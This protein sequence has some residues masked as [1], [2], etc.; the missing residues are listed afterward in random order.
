MSGILQ[1]KLNTVE[2]LIIGL[3]FS[4]PRFIRSLLRSQQ[5]LKVPRLKDGKASLAADDKARR[6]P[7]VLH[8]TKYKTIILKIKVGLINI[9]WVYLRWN[10]RSE[11]L[12][13]I[14]DNSLRRYPHYS[15]ATNHSP[16]PTFW[17]N[18]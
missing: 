4:G 5:Q 9:L 10:D 8:V 15:L 11:H 16:L 1:N 14:M 12:I 7:T 17:T 3:D 18:F 6:C 13:D 2:P